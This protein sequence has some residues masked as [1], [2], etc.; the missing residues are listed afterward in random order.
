MPA[1]QAL[2]FSLAWVLTCAAL[3]ACGDEQQPEGGNAKRYSGEQKRVA[4]VV[5]EL[6][7]ASRDGDAARIC[8]ELFTDK[9]A[10]VISVRASGK[11]CEEPVRKQQLAENASIRVLAIRLHGAAA[12]AHV[13]EQNGNRTTLELVKQGGDWRI[14]SIAATR[15][16]K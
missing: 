10:G 1:R 2:A 6:Q 4:E 14:D 12:S 13:R 9:L 16:K 3:G 7:A 11:P 5:D 8:D 15:P